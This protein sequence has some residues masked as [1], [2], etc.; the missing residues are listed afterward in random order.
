MADENNLLVSPIFG[1]GEGVGYGIVCIMTIAIQ[2]NH[3]SLWQ[4]PPLLPDDHKYTRGHVLLLGGASMTGA[5][6]LAALAAQRVGAGLV[7]LAAPPSAWPVYATALMSVITHKLTKDAG[8]GWLLDQRKVN[9]VLLGPG[10]D[11]LEVRGRLTAAIKRSKPLVLDAGALTL[12]AHAPALREKLRDV[13]FILLPHEGEYRALAQAIGLDTAADKPE[14]ALALAQALGGVVLLKGADTYIAAPD[15]RVLLQET[16]A[17]WLATG[18]TGDVLAGI[19]AGLV[20]QGMGMFEA[21]ASAAWLH[22]EAA[23]AFGAGMVA[24]D[25]IAVLPEALAVALSS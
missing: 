23:Q 24:E 7:T 5:A 1:L 13:P 14:R 18:G 22:S 4:I 10:T 2:R 19:V 20:A 6:R 11:P 9:V 15:G 3:P 12:L 25:L 8:F 21:A 17:P 16:Q